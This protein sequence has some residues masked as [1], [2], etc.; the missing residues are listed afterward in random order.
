MKFRKR[1]TVF[2]GVRLNFS[3][4]G[5]ST[6]VGVP[7]ANVNINRHGTFLN[8]GIPGTGLYDRHR[9]GGGRKN[10]PSSQGS[11]KVSPQVSS[12]FISYVPHTRA[13]EYTSPSLEPLHNTL[14]DCYN[15]RK[16]L[17]ADL[18]IAHK[19]I[20]KARGVLLFS[21]VLIFGFFFRWFRNN[22]VEKQLYLQELTEALEGC[23]VDIDMGASSKWI[24]SYEKLI[25]TY[26]FLS[27]SEVIWDLIARSND[28]QAYKDP[29]SKNIRRRVLITLKNLGFIQSQYDALHFENADGGD[30]YLYPGFIA[31]VDDC[32]AF[33]VLDLVDVSLTFSTERIPETSKIPED[34][35][36]A[37]YT[38]AKANK[39]GSPDRRFRD[40]YQIPVCLYG[41]ISIRSKNGLNE[42]WLFSNH[43]A[44]RDFVA[45]YRE[46]LE[47][48]RGISQ[49]L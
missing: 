32:G 23:K 39:D 28:P 13:E 2:P 17:M 8:T 36:I 30:L 42:S 10:A 49:E 41:N 45:A 18:S 11:S 24:E 46:F 37:G 33:G 35:P 14:L 44:A 16:S 22:V 40:N 21:R 27:S 26:H 5:I 6:T 29:G 3:R 43:D 4:S 31:V 15:E 38:W 7:G 20:A 19:E 9:I 1:V 48:T 25:K 34:V 47:V 12:G